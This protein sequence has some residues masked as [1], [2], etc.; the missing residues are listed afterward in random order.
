ML[1]SLVAF[2]LTLLF[3]PKMA[4]SQAALTAIQGAIGPLIPA[5]NPFRDQQFASDAVAKMRSSSGGFHRAAGDT[6]V[7]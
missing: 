5:E 7:S 1:E 4:P 3:T 2:A 6:A